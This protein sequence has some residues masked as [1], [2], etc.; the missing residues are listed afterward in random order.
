MALRF[1]QGGDLR[2]P[3]NSAIPL[4]LVRILLLSPRRKRAC[5]LGSYLPHAPVPHPGG[6]RQGDRLEELSKLR[7][8]TGTTGVRSRRRD[9]LG[10]TSSPPSRSAVPHAPSSRR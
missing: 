6:D 9:A 1:G 10:T 4:P 5:S 8:A 3:M 7:S 2:D